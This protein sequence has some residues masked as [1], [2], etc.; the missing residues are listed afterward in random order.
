[1]GLCKKILSREKS[2]L[3]S[4]NDFEI[5]SVSGKDGFP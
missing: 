2:E 4:G 3:G 5:S 1:M